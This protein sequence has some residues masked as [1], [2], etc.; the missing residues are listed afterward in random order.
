MNEQSENS[1]LKFT[2]HFPIDGSSLLKNHAF[3]SIQMRQH[4]RMMI[5]IANGT[6]SD[7]L[8]CLVTLSALSHGD[9]ITPISSQQFLANKHLKKC[10]SVSS[11]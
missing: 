10:L 8:I 7:L 1:F 3:L 11:H 4:M 9:I 2:Q 5:S 6:L